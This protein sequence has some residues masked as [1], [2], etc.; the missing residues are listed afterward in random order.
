M[1]TYLKNSVIY[2]VFVRNFTKEGDFKSL[3]KKLEYIKYLGC[4]II[5]LLPICPI[6]IV[7]RKGTLGSPYAIKDYNEINEEYGSWNDFK[8]L[9]NKTHSLDMKI[10]LDI[11]Y[12]HTSRDSKLLNEHPEWFYKDKD[13]NFANKL[14]D[15]SDVYDLDYSSSQLQ[16]Y[17]IN[18]LEKYLSLGVDGFRFDVGSLIPKSFWY[19][20]KNR[21]LSKYPNTIML[22]ESIDYSFNL[23]A[24]RQGFNGLSDGEFITNGFDLLYEYNSRNYLNKYF[25]TLDPLYF[26]KY[27]TV[28]ANEYQALPEGGLRIRGY[29]NHDSLRICELTKNKQLR[30][31]IL[32][33]EFFLD[34]CSFVCNGL[35]TKQSKHISLFDKDLM[36]T[37][38][39]KEWFNLVKKLI[40]IK[41]NEENRDISLSSISEE[42]GLYLAIRNDYRTIHKYS[43]GLFNFSKKELKIKNPYLLD[44]KYKD[45]I[46][47]SILEVKDN[48]LVISEPLILEKID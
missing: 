4:N 22:C 5:Q 41:R 39:D 29:E 19:N 35:E 31:N 36:D 17:L 20:V 34:G 43:L 25:E 28:L 8:K 46:S 10:I 9:I 6:G 3:T 32:A 23:E 37:H 14:G 48:S 13:G 26:E 33:Y 30:R 24:R 15:W 38:I 47:D 2:Q 16:T 45:L 21:L 1:K 44:G 27:K 40:S 18:S 7:G 42:K 11:V 12:N